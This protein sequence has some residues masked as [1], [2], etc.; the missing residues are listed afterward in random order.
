MPDTQIEMVPG[1]SGASIDPE[2]GE[3][4][5]WS[6]PP[7]PRVSPPD[8][9]SIERI[10]RN[11]LLRTFQEHPV[12]EATKHITQAIQFQGHRGYQKA[13]QDGVP[14]EKALARYGPMM[15]YRAPQAFAPAVK[16]LTPP[17]MT[18]YQT[19]RLGLERERMNKPVA[20]PQNKFF[21]SGGDI[22]SIDPQ[23]GEVVKRITPP[24]S[25]P[26]VTE[27]I[28]MVPNTAMIQ[29]PGQ[30]NTPPFLSLTNR[31]T[32]GIPMPAPPPAT[33]HMPAMGARAMMENR[34]RLPAD[35]T[36]SATANPP[37]ERVVHKATP[38]AVGGYVIGR[39]YRGGLKYLGG[40]PKL[41]ASWEKTK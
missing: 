35:L 30:T 34:V 32:R 1:M 28:N 39:I 38:V 19:A 26:T 10:D 7:A 5:E 6:L 36:A 11:A 9:Y 31:T 23:T 2:T 41:E 37:K 16:A 3:R 15:F 40:D 4:R 21:K 12:D 33:E 24:P 22:V 17:V 18:P 27:S 20:V 25:I 13:I 14:P 8:P 29:P